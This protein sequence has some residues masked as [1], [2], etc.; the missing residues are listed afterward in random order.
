MRICM[1]SYISKN[2]F[3]KYLPSHLHLLIFPNKFPF[4]FIFALKKAQTHTCESKQESGSE[5]QARKQSQL[6]VHVLTRPH[7]TTQPMHSPGRAQS[8]P[9]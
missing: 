3:L 4:V 8:K 9:Q 6:F 5:S 7:Q 2:I 1:F